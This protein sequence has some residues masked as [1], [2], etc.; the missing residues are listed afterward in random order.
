MFR[1]RDIRVLLSLSGLLVVPVILG[2][3]QSPPAPLP[4][5]LSLAQAEDLLIQRNLTILAARFQ[6]DAN[7][8]A[9]L[10][11]TYRPNPVVTVGMEQVPFYSPI[12]GSYP[13][14][15]NTN[16]DAGANPVYTVRVDNIWERGAKRQLR[17]EQADF[18]IK[19]SEAQMLDAVRQQVFQLRQAFVAAT[20]ARENL[21]LAETVVQEYEQTERL[22]QAKVDLGDE[23]GLELYRARAGR[24]QFQQ[25]VLQARSVYEQA[26]RDVLL[27][28]GARPEEVVPAQITEVQDS[29]PILASS[30]AAGIGGARIETAS[31]QIGQAQVAESLRA[32]PLEL[33]WQ[34]DNRPVT[35]N[36]AELRSMTLEQRPD[37]IAARDTLEAAERVLRLARA[38]R[39][40]DVDIAYEYQRVGNDHSVGVV[41]QFPL[42]T[43]N[44]QRAGITQAEAQRRAAETQ[45]KQ[46]EL[47]A[48]TEVEK[49]Y[50]FYLT[51]K[52]ALDL[53]S[54]QNLAQLEKLRTIATYSYQQGASSLIQLLDAQRY[55]NQALTAYNQARA[56]YQLSLWQLEQAVGH[57]LR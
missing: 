47:K 1:S 3:A 5:Q 53:Y 57:S 8:A 32:A 21:A 34:F 37:V 25:A 23:A 6:I 28:L 15:W 10:I 50:Q 18:Q 40:R 20:L 27:L 36:V 30:E 55:Y 9:R 29:K 49:A 26:T 52:Q 24:L 51:T 38:Q 17:T 54:S 14:F 35:Q 46:S 22:T 48:I 41:V 19:A 7:R 11:A 13:R 56:D 45:L 33:L 39:V 42:F 4:R 16:S 43:Y 2:Q 44:N 12:K 31:P